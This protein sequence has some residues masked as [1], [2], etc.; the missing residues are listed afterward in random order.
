M[1]PMVFWASLAPC[2][3][4]TAAA[5][6]SCRP[7]NAFASSRM[8]QRCWIRAKITIARNATVKATTGEATMA[9]TAVRTTPQLIAARPPAAS[10]AP[11]R[12]PMI[13]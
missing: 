1:M 7:L 6:T 4:E 9:I 3:K 10:P 5:E 13:A 8:C 12:P 11:T 2:P